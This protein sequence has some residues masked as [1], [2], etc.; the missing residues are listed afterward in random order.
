M[1][2]LSSCP[3]KTF[4]PE[5]PKRIIKIYYTFSTVMKTCVFFFFGCLLPKE[6]KPT[7]RIAFAI[8]F[9][10]AAVLS[11]LFLLAVFSFFFFFSLFVRIS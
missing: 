6:K 8:C 4:R 10:L 11:I 5:S 1:G 2:T 7:R 9:W 3:I